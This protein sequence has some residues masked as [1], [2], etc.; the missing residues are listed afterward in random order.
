MWVVCFSDDQELRELYLRDVVV[1]DF[2]GKEI[3]QLP[4]VYL[5]RK[6]DSI[7]IEFPYRDEEEKL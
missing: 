4:S 2:T 6:A 3:M 1:Y 5:S 7:N